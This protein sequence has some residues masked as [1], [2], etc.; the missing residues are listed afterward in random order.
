V[1]NLSVAASGNGIAGSCPP[2]LQAAIQDAVGKGAVLVAGS[3][4]DGSGSN[5]PVYP[6]ACKGVL[7]VGAIDLAR[8]AWVDTQRQPYVDVAAPGV[9]MQAIDDK[10]RTGTSEGTSD[11]TALA[12]GAVALVWSKYPALTNRQVVARILAT[13]R[14]DTDQPGRDDATGGGII[15]PY[16]AI[17]QNIPANAPNPVFDELTQAPTPVIPSAAP[18]PTQTCMS[19][20]PG[21]AVATVGP[22]PSGTPTAA[23][24]TCASPASTDQRDG[25]S[26]PV[27]I[28]VLAA[29]LVG[30]SLLAGS[31]VARRRRNLAL[32]S[33]PPQPR[34]P[35]PEPKWP[36]TH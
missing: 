6:A 15:R 10:G 5:P 12:S 26:T 11:A 19:A 29:M 4:N 25:P 30:G 16:N 28:G 2:D 23:A 22:P 20:R 35:Q 32:Q 24:P 7:A 14:D 1:L 9:N 33:G 36:P 17:T 13:L 18:A 21:H 27:L 34:P 3:G 31:L 8:H